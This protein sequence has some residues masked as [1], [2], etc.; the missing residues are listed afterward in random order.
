[1]ET[2]ADNVS[3]RVGVTQ[4]FL[5]ILHPNVKKTGGY[6]YYYYYYCYYTLTYKDTT[7]Y[8]R[9]NSNILTEAIYFLLH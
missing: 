2:Y 3:G 9:I 6:Y 7:F 1:L 8:T 4:V 5:A